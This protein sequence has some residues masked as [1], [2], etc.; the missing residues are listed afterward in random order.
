MKNKS[1]N[2]RGLS[3]F[4][5]R[6]QGEGS[7]DNMLELVKPESARERTESVL[8]NILRWADDGGQMLDPG[9]SVWLKHVRTV[10]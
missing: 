5:Q 7:P 2:R 9:N 4:R 6:I 3:Y 1:S 8:K 10:G